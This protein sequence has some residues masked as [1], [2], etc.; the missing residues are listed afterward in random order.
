M[1]LPGHLRDGFVALVIEGDEEAEGLFFYDSDK[2]E[3]WE[4][5]NAGERRRWLCGQLWNCTDVLP[6]FYCDEVG[7]PQGSTYA[8]AARRIR[9]TIAA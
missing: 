8:Q 5:M 4:R 6:V 2:Q 1:H 3:Q 7:L 9:Q